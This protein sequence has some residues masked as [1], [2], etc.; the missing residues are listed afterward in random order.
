MRLVRLALHWKVLLFVVASVW[1]PVLVT[2]A[3]ASPSQ[4]VAGA[5]FELVSVPTCAKQTPRLG[6]ACVDKS[7]L[8]VAEAWKVADGSAQRNTDFYQTSFSWNVPKTIPPAGASMTLKLT[9]AGLQGNRIC[10]DIAVAGSFVA[11]SKHLAACAESGQSVNP[12]LTVK[13]V[14]PS[15]AAGTVVSLIVW[16]LDGPVYTYKYSAVGAAKKAPKCRRPSRT[17]AAT[18]ATPGFVQPET[19][20]TPKRTSAGC[21]VSISFALLHGGWPKDAPKGFFDVTTNG[22]GK[23]TV[24]SPV[25]PH[26]RQG[27]YAIR[28]RM[29]DATVRVVRTIHINNPKD[30]PPVKK[31]RLVFRADPSHI[32]VYRRDGVDDQALVVPLELVSS[33][34]LDCRPGIKARLELERGGLLGEDLFRLGTFDR[35]CNRYHREIF[36]SGGPGKKPLVRISITVK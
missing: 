24:D 10:P 15:A 36:A 17:G 1:V 13:L 2:G 28:A 21:E 29:K 33:N 31:A 5:R 25:N 7:H 23:V 19:S 32:V 14:P 8:V 16:I 27:R 35:D 18:S 11:T 4:P 22:I 34:D 6:R 20:A 9:A 3:L 30:V 12:S 26:T